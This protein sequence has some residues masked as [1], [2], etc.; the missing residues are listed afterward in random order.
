MYP[1]C[2]RTRDV[3]RARARVLARAYIHLRGRTCLE[4]ERAYVSAYNP[5]LVRV[6]ECVYV[7][8]C[9]ICGMRIG[10]V[11]AVSRRRNRENSTRG[12]TDRWEA[13][14]GARGDEFGVELSANEGTEAGGRG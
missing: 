5:P 2:I 9:G 10:V 12:E 6:P 14:E 7:C 4:R 8:V 11:K 1:P 3:A 13:R